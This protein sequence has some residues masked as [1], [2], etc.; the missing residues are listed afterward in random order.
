MKEA[1]NNTHISFMNTTLYNAMCGVMGNV[2]Y[3]I[4]KAMPAL[5]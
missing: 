1:T 4:G 2:I 5:D 3:E